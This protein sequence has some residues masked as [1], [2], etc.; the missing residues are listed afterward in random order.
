MPR[1]NHILPPSLRPLILAGALLLLC[2][3]SCSRVQSIREARTIVAEAD[4]LRN[5]GQ[6]L[7]PSAFH[8]STSQ[9]DSTTI[10]SAVSTLEH[11]RLIYPTAYAHANYYYGRLLREAGNQPEAMLAFLRVVHSRTQ[12]HEIIA[13]SWSNIANMCRLAADH[14]MAYDIYVRSAEEF[15]KAKDTTTYYYAL[16]NMAFE[17]AEEGRKDEAISIIS[18]IESICK[19]QGVLT[20][21]WE[22]RADA[23]IQAQMYDSTIYCVRQL[24]ARGNHE[25]TGILLKAKAYSFLGVK[26]SAVIYAEQAVQCTN[27]LFDL[28][29][30][31][32]ILANE[33]ATKDKEEALQCTRDRADIQKLIEIRQG[34]LSQATQ[35]LQQDL[36][37]K[38]NLT[39]LWTLLV[40]LCIIATS[41]SIY[42]RKKKAKRQL[43]SQQVEALQQTRDSLS[44]QTRQIENEQKLRQE[45]MLAE[46]ELFCNSIT[47]EN[48]KKELCWIDFTQM[49]TIVNQRMFGLVDKLKAR[50]ITSMTEIRICVLLALDRFNAKQMANVIPCTYD[51][52][53]TTKSLIVKKLNVSRENIH[54]Y[55]I[56]LA[57][58][59]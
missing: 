38:P 10:A 11:V 23:Y 42:I 19:D 39:W 30:A 52:F 55:L 1:V 5:A 12:D 35:L 50:G 31:Y 47:E 43:I 7:S 41:T 16:N 54:S 8:L 4:S 6:S 57:V 27:S 22:T 17:R 48:M 9:S 24:Q 36:N 49:C 53:K 51:S 46:I 33:D 56:N 37:R 21:N 18:Q 20:K 15:L 44:A 34:Q 40:T 45:K 3:S 25:P 59:G 32:Y 14:K 58:G 26:D 13:R 28:N 29:N 2:L